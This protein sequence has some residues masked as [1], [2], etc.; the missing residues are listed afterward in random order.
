MARRLRSPLRK[1]RKSPVQLV[2]KVK[3]SKSVRRKSGKRKSGRR[4]SKSGRR[5]SGRRKRSRRDGSCGCDNGLADG[6]SE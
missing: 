4:K 6:C 2:C 1:S 5:K 3:K